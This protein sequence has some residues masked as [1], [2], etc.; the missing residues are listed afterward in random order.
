MLDLPGVVS[1]VESVQV[2]PIYYHL[3][4][5]METRENVKVEGRTEYKYQILVIK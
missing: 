5:M 1:R 4:M 2:L 3:A